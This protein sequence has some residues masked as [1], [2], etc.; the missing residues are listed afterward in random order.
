MFVIQFGHDIDRGM[1]MG[2]ARVILLGGL[3]EG[4]QRVG[5]GGQTFGRHRGHSSLWEDNWEGKTRARGRREQLPLLESPT[6]MPIPN[7][8]YSLVKIECPN[9][10]SHFV[11]KSVRNLPLEIIDRK[12]STAEFYLLKLE[13]AKSQFVS[14]TAFWAPKCEEGV[15]L[16]GSF[17]VVR[18]KPINFFLKAVHISNFDISSVFKQID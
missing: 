13:S 16:E 10:C 7:S 2:G 5:H 17:C 3:W 18:I 15:K 6:G 4:G 9:W 8:N 11:I 14:F 1:T 12:N